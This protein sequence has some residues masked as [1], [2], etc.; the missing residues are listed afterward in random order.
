MES[1]EVDS[2][3]HILSASNIRMRRTYPRLDRKLT[4]RSKEVPDKSEETHST[5][6]VARQMLAPEVSK[7][8]KAEYEE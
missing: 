5:A 8:E 2:R 1:I 7:K 3:S 6:Y 4:I